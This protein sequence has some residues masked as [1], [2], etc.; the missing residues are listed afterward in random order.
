MSS[1]LKIGDVEIGGRVLIAPMTGVSDLPFRRVASR[2]GAAYVATEM[3]ASAE[4]A[5]GR[6]DVVRRAAVG[7]GLPLT[8]IQLVGRD[9]EMMAVGARMAEAA[10]ADLIDLNFGCPAKEVTGVLCGSALMRD[11]DRALELI[12][13]AVNATS[14]PVTVKMRLGWDEASKTAPELAARAAAAGVKA[15]TVHARTRQQFYGGRADWSAVAAVKAEVSVPVI[16]NGDVVDLASARAALEQSGADAVMLGR[17]VYGRPWLAAAL[18]QG[19]AGGGGAAEPGPEARLA[20]VIEHF[21]EALAFYGDRLGLKIFRKHL[22][23]YVEQ[24]PWPADAGVRR[25]AKARLCRLE[26]PA[27]VERE[28]ATL[29][30]DEAL[31]TAA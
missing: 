16:V 5:R 20:L 25:A 13:A 4:L 27:E 1:G 7:D 3:V 9:P 31:R 14:R 12:E 21:R 6:P 10:G 22:G 11:L 29:W 8:V 26:S 28:L 24:A 23:W 17:G 19:L 30:G 2:T 18:E 15:V